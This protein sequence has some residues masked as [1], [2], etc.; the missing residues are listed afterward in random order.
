MKG[1]VENAHVKRHQ[2]YSC[3][4]FVGSV[5]IGRAWTKHESA[6]RRKDN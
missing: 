3:E 6:E 1:E 2:K 4:L 5:Q